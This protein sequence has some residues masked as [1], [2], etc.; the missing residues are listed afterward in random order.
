MKLMRVMF[1]VLE[2]FRITLRKHLNILYILIKT[3]Y[4]L[5][6]VPNKKY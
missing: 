1:M 4:H 3:D 5:F 2:S 6:Y